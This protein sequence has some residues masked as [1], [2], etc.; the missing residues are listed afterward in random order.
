VYRVTAPASLA[1]IRSDDRSYP[2]SLLQRCET[3]LVLFAAG[4]HGLNDGVFLADAGI[5]ATC[6]DTDAE[7]LNEMLRIYPD[8]WTF[9]VADAYEYATVSGK[10]DLVSVDPYTNQFQRCADLVDAW[11]ALARVAVVL[12]TGV[13]TKVDPPA[14][15][16]ITETRFRTSYDGGTFWTVLERLP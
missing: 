5:R 13:G 6:V 11:C 4:F 9:V 10:W 14:G 7:K 3:A 16:E 12:G 1:E 8:D 15:W 2:R